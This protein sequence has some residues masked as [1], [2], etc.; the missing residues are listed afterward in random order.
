MKM[1]AAVVN[2]EKRDFELEEIEL[3]APKDNE[4]LIKLVATGVC[5]TDVAGQDGLTTPMP[6]VLGHEGAGIVEQVG[7]AVSSVK[8]GDKVILSFSYCGKCRNC[9]EGHPGMCEKFN[10]LNFAGPNFDGTHRMH[11]DRHDLSLFFGQSSFATYTVVDEHNIVKVPDDA[12]VDLAYLGPLGCGLQTGS[13]SVLNYLKPEPGATIAIFGMGPVG[14]AA[15]LGAKV[16]GAKRI[17][18]FDRK[19]SK[20]AFAKEFG[21]TDC[22]NSLQVNPEEVIK[23]IEPGGVDFSLD[24]TGVPAVAET[25]VH[26]LRPAGEA[27]LVGIGGDLKL[28]MMTN[29]VAESKKVAGLV[30]GDAIPQKFIP[31]MIKYYQEGRFAFDKLIKVYDFKDLNQAMDDFKAGKVLK[32]VV[33]M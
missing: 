7:A 6:V 4:V 16:A 3:D 18:V 17:I 22:Y 27:V 19:E 30:E 21:A 33:K 12:D 15:V 1:T 26:I 11:K 9:L 25:A 10:D 31:E 13:G 32:P 5:H 28:Y 20:L 24:T 8:P 23:D 14:L 29:L 2:G